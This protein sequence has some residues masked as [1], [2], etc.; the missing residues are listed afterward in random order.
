MP[1]FLSRARLASLFAAAALSA[2][3]SGSSPNTCNT[4]ADC[5]ANQTCQAGQCLGAGQCPNGILSCTNSTQCSAG[6]ACTNGCCEPVEGCATSADCTSAQRPHCDTS[7]HACVICTDNTECLTGKVCTA[8]GACEPACTTDSNCSFPTPHCATAGGYCAQ[9]I[10]DTQCSASTPFCQN[11]VC[12]GCKSN[13]D[14]SGATP[15][16]DTTQKACVACLDSQSSGGTNS[17]CPASTPACENGACVVCDPSQNAASGA[18]GACPNTTPSCSASSTCVV[19]TLSSECP[20]GNTCDPTSNTCSAVA[21]VTFTSSASTVLESGFATLTAAVNGDV[22]SP[23]TI[24]VDIASGGVGGT[25]SSATIVISSGHTGTVTYTAPASAGSATVEAK[26]NGAT[27]TAAISVS[28]SALALQS[29][30]LPAGNSAP[31]SALSATVTLNAAPSADATVSVSA[32]NGATINGAASANITVPAGS[33]TS[34]PFTLQLACNTSLTVVS[35]ALSTAPAAILQQNVAIDTTQPTLS[36]LAPSSATVGMGQA[37]GLTATLSGP[38]TCG[39]TRVYLAGSAA[40]YNSN[41]KYNGY[42][43]SYITVP[44]GQTSATVPVV[45]ECYGGSGDTINIIG[46]T[47]GTTA[48]GNAPVEAS[49]LVVVSSVSAGQLVFCPISPVT[50]DRPITYALGDGGSAPLPELITVGFGEYKVDGGTYAV[51]LSATLPDGGACGIFQID[52][53]T[54]AN[55]A[56]PFTFA[57]KQELS[58]VPSATGTCSLQATAQVT[59]LGG[60]PTTYTAAIPSVYNLV[61]DSQAAAATPADLVLTKAEIDEDTLI[62]TDGGTNHDGGVYGDAAEYIE[63]FNPTSSSINLAGYSLVFVGGPFDNFD[64]GTAQVKSEYNAIAL[65]GTVAAGH[66]AIVQDSTTGLTNTTGNIDAFITL[67]APAGRASLSGTT[68]WRV[69]NIYNAPGGIFL[70]KNAGSVNASIVDGLNYGAPV[71]QWVSPSITGSAS[72]VFSWPPAPLL[73]LDNWII[74]NAFVKGSLVRVGFTGSPGLD[75][76]DST[77]VVPGAPNTTITGP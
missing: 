35:A 65:S 10:N 15:V 16:C 30:D 44:Q 57:N 49:A 58:F 6:N 73:P 26:L 74:D 48:Q 59:P 63:L 47:Q 61:D 14:C 36:S 76:V 31:G 40:L 55:G 22:T 28:A 27:L 38:A 66:Y 37:I 70:V 21:L 77:T 12:T 3:S 5:A 8:T 25:L 20:Q 45:P 4:N 46:S 60:S 19:C 69:G 56:V 64:G 29:I 72:G 39:G 7:T 52:G 68:P 33:Q 11:N 18:N 41:S 43:P 34:A 51:N 13:A 53:G 50:S 62:A 75:W 67:T 32:N 42:I 24:N 17:A 1:S 2:C 54:L 9:C 71:M 23:I